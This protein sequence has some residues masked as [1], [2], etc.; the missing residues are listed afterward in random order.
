MD[1]SWRGEGSEMNNPLPR[2][3]ISRLQQRPGWSDWEAGLGLGTDGGRFQGEALGEASQTAVR[4][5]RLRRGGGWRGKKV[6]SSWRW[7]GSRAPVGWGPGW[8]NCWDSGLR[9]AMWQHWASL[10]GTASRASFPQHG[11]AGAW[12]GSWAGGEGSNSGRPGR[13]SAPADGRRPGV[14]RNG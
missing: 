3:E 1:Q 13:V 11:S 6:S 7:P 2:R 10:P 12:P 9:P 5:L 8:P 14:S 4:N